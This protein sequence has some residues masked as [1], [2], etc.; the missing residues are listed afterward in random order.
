MELVIKKAS[1]DDASAIYDIIQEAFTKYQSDLGVDVKVAALTETVED[2]KRD[3]KHKCVFIALL[4]DIPVGTVRYEIDED[5]IAYL[6]RFGVKLAYQKYGIGTALMKA[7]EQ[8]AKEHGAK[9][10][11]LHT[12]LKM[13]NLIKFYQR[14]GYYIDS[15][16]SHTGYARA[17][18]R[19]P[20]QEEA[21]AINQSIAMG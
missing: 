15:T 9:A 11:T 21:T 16:S 18:L 1:T 17:L 5:G 14:L 4:D 6:S 13:H 8:D 2:I 12:A 19:K 20:I 10:I 7:L 3:I